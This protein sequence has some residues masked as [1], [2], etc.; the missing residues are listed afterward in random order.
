MHAK[1]ITQYGSKEA[2]SQANYDALTKKHPAGR[3]KN[4][5]LF[6]WLRSR[7]ASHTRARVA[8]LA[9]ALASGASDRKVVEVR[10]L[11]RA[12]NLP[13]SSIREVGRKTSGCDQAAVCLRIRNLIDGLAAFFE[14]LPIRFKQS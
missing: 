13:K 12:P 2:L 10:V 14:S 9:D 1:R 4:A 8:E 3:I 11:S 6:S 7:S 5:S